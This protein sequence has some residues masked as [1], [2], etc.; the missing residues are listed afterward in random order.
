M[1]I[2]RFT[3]ICLIC[4]IFGIGFAQLVHQKRSFGTAH[5]HATQDYC[6]GAVQ[7]WSCAGLKRER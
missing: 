3:M 2:R 1:L 4:M 7:H 6:Y 5:A